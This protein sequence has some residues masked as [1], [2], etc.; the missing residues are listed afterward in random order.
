MVYDVD[1]WAEYMTVCNTAPVY[2]AHSRLRIARVQ[3]GCREYGSRSVHGVIQVRTNRMA[4][5]T[6]IQ[7]LNR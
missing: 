6:A 4:M 2:Q 5:G 1:E 7:P 3:T